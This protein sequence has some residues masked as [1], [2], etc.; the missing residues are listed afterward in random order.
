MK[1][2]DILKKDIK[3]LKK[4]YKDCNTNNTIYLRPVLKNQIESLKE[5]IFNLEVQRF[6]DFI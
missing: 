2:I 1:D 4:H 5:T 3:A 6:K